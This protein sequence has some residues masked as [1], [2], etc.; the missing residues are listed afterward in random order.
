M[1]GS[2]SKATCSRAATLVRAAYLSVTYPITCKTLSP[3]TLASSSAPLMRLRPSSAAQRWAG[4]V[5]STYLRALQRSPARSPARR[6]LRS[7]ATSRTRTLQ[8]L[9]LRILPRLVSPMQ[10]VLVSLPRLPG[11]LL[12]LGSESKQVSMPNLRNSDGRSGR[13]VDLFLH[14][15]LWSC[16]F[17]TGL[18]LSEWRLHRAFRTTSSDGSVWPTCRHHR[19]NYFISAQSLTYSRVVRHMISEFPSTK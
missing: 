14:V 5:R 11:G 7:S 6:T 4:L 13:R 8:T 17:V 1:S 16:L 18:A 19:L 15:K 9:S 2:M 3:T 10:L 12:S